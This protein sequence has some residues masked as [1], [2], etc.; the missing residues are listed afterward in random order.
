MSLG[1]TSTVVMSFPPWLVCHISV[2]FPVAALNFVASVEGDKGSGERRESK[3]VNYIGN[4]T[5]QLDYL[6]RLINIISVQNLTQENV[7]CLNTTLV[8]LMFANKRN[9]LPLYLQ[10]LGEKQ[11]EA[12]DNVSGSSSI[13]QNFRWVLLVHPSGGAVFT[14]KVHCSPIR[15]IMFTHQVHCSPIRWTAF[16]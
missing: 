10:A 8:F 5:R 16:T 11:D 13:L 1:N 3:L 4:F 9:Q 12:L 15:W 6:Y 14:H 2:C 7:S